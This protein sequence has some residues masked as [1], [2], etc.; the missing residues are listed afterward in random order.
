MDTTGNP[1]IFT[2]IAN[3]DKMGKMEEC[4]VDG[5]EVIKKAGQS[6]NQWWMSKAGQK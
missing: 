2:E 6:G 1:E 4:K 5:S 3:M